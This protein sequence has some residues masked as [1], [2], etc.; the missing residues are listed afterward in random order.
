MGASH[1]SI[2]SVTIMICT[3]QRPEMLAQCLSSAAALKRVDGVDLYLAL[4]DNN[5]ESQ[6]DAYIKDMLAALPFPTSYRHVEKRGYSSARNGAI[7]LALE[8]PSGVFAFIDDDLLLKP[9]WL[10]G[11]VA[12]FQELECDAILGLIEGDPKSRRHG[13]LLASA[14]MANFA[15]KRG[16]V[17]ADGLGLRF[18]PAFDLLGYEDRAFTKA[19][20]STGQVAR[21]SR[22][23]G[24][25]DCDR[26]TGSLEELRNKAEVAAAAARNKVV[27]LRKQRKFLQLTGALL[28]GC[29]NG[30]KSLG[31]GIQ[32]EIC[33][34][35]DHGDKYE[36]LKIE[37]WKE[38]NKMLGAF[39]GLS[40]DFAPRQDVRRGR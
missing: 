26:Q 21:F 24:V 19:A 30:L 23:V 31:L 38:R 12:S 15:F 1:T 28:A 34:L 32:S 29:H 7:E 9:D 33:R 27:A 35:R 5:T 25:V 22:H 11:L 13:E 17:S 6:Y 37:R 16:I 14:G 10:S 4:V 8:T 39:M 2:S 36:R 20:I 18:D 40:Q 3:Y